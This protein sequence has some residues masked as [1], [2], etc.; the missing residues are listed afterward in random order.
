MTYSVYFTGSAD[1]DL[2]DILDYIAQDS[3]ENALYF[4]DQLQSR[5]IN[6]LG[7]QPFT[8]LRH[9]DFYYI[10][11]DNYIVVYDIDQSSSAV[12][13]HM[14]TEGHRQWK[15]ILDKRF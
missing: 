14:I 6:L 1:A 3:L 10:S 9:Q 12:Y 8:G 15:A 7:E 5:I 11:F 2:E 13:I 4:T